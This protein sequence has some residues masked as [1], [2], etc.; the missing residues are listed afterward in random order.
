[1]GWTRPIDRQLDW[2]AKA[3]VGR[4]VF[5]HCGSPIVRATS[6]AID[7]LVGQLSREYGL[8][9]RIARDGD[10]LSLR[11][12]VGRDSLSGKLDKQLQTCLARKGSA[13]LLKQA[14]SVVASKWSVGFVAP[15]DPSSLLKERSI[16]SK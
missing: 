10:S 14:Q 7:A 1:M 16:A 9:V 5:T 6:R 15:G 2:C 4:V 13:F 11:P 8:D 12:A 3:H